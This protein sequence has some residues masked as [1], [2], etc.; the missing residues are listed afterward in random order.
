M[1]NQKNSG[2][3]LGEKK[4]RISASRGIDAKCANLKNYD[5]SKTSFIDDH[6][7]GELSADAITLSLMV[8]VLSLNETISRVVTT[9]LRQLIKVFYNHQNVSNKKTIKTK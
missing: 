4:V 6:K 3:A 1:I 2:R 9:Q 8:V 7:T 5:V